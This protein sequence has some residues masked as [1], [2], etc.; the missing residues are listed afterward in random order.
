MTKRIIGRGQESRGLY[1][2]DQ[3]FP[4]PIAYSRIANPL[5]VHCRLDHPSLS[6]LK[7]LFPQFPSLSSLN[8]ES[9]QYAKLCPMHLSP[10]VNKR[11]FELVYSNVW[12]PSPVM[13]PTKFKYF[14]TLRLLMLHSLRLS[15][16]LC[17]LLL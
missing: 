8:C 1:I 7:K 9:C 5:E 2:L 15:R 3:K 12:G 4:K 16:F 17:R 14:V 13:S 11:A 6:L 10:K